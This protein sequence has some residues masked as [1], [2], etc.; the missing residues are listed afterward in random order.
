MVDNKDFA[1][2][3]DVAR[4]LVESE[5]V[6]ALERVFA[7]PFEI[8]FPPIDVTTLRVFN[9][10]TDYFHPEGIEIFLDGKMIALPRTEYDVR[11]GKEYHGRNDISAVELNVRKKPFIFHSRRE[12][13]NNWIEFVFN[14]PVTI[15]EVHIYQREGVNVTR[16]VSLA[17]SAID[18]DG[19]NKLLFSNKDDAYT[20]IRAGLA[21]LGVHEP[22]EDY[23]DFVY[24]LMCAL[25][26]IWTNN[27][28]LINECFPE[29]RRRAQA[30][31]FINDN[32]LLPKKRCSRPM[33]SSAHL[34]VGPKK[35][36]ANICKNRLR[37]FASLMIS[38][39]MLFMLMAHF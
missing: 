4:A 35:K 34:H 8:S 11:G 18:N 6:P 24:L 13:I 20:Q 10:D 7:L 14:S 3:L 9:M 31:S 23:I 32:I 21:G 29:E 16:S 36:S 19:N 12:K 30:T 2:A 37:L 22:S 25:K 26:G 15:D 17:V 5:A 1:E 28:V 38:L 27:D 33:A 39:Q